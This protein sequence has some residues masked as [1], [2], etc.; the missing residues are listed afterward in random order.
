MF[1]AGTTTAVKVGDIAPNFELSN[2]FGEPV[3]LHS[4]R[5]APVVVVFYPFAFSRVCTSEMCEL[6]DNLADFAALDARV[7]AISVDSKFTLRAYAA[8]ENL[9]FELL[10]DFWPHGAVASQFGAFDPER[11]MAGRFSFIIDADGIVRAVIASPPGE[12]RPLD[13]YRQALAAL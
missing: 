4:L 5:G 7:L 8:E 6:R 12:S 13:R 11:G 1:D 9:N 10:A 2:Q 3:S